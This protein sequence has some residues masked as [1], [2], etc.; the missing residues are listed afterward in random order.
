MFLTLLHICV[1]N[2]VGRMVMAEFI[3]ITN[4]FRTGSVAATR[5]LRLSQGK[6][7]R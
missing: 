3:K 5:V 7:A 2:V 6:L 4:K 1:A